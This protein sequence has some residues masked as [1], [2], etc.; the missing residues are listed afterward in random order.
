MMTKPQISRV[1]AREILDSRGNPTVEATVF[2]TD[3]TVGVASVPSGASTGVF[4]ACELRDGDRSRYGGKGVK[5]A[6]ANVND[7]ISPALSGV[8]VSEQGEV[9]RILCE[10]DGTEDKHRLGA[11]AILAVSLASARAA[12]NWYHLPLY[13]Y[14]GGAAA[15]RLPV[16]MMNILNGGA[17]AS[18]NVEIQ[19]FMIAPVGAQ[20][21]AEGLRM[22]SEIYRML[23]KILH[24][25]GHATTVGDE[26]GYAPN[27]SSDDEALD[28]I[29]RAIEECGFN[30][31]QVKIALDCATGE[32]YNEEDGTYRLPKRG[33]TK[34]RT[35]LIQNWE[36]L[37]SKYPIFSI[38]D[39]LDQ[40]DFDGWVDLTNR[41]G[42]H[43]MLVGDDL[44]VTNEKRLLEGIR[45]GAANS[46]LIK[47]NQIGTLSEVLR[48]IET[49][50]HHGYGFIPSHRSG[51]TEDSTLADLAVAT[52]AHFIKTGAPCR[53]ERVAKYNRL[54]RIESA[55]AA[56]ARYGEI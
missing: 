44:F 47:P 43:V 28:F 12:A 19:E 6:V 33:E 9:D 25:E 34:S 54:L 27:L 7:S 23:G 15:H 2:L 39:G 45:R 48:V 29:C 5:K 1:T 10:L 22:G 51:D 31:N 41:L 49:A 30:E 40:R 13:R 35:E 17:H 24:S 37:V 52:N 14:L 32:W 4:E 3:G 18:N 53:S 21:F 55:L 46:I 56:S 20:N 26:G 8:Y 11:N 50:R 38:E 16:P 42:A 36:R